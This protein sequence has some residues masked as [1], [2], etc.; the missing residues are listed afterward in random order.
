MSNN[1]VEGED[2]G[3]YVATPDNINRMARG[4]APVGWDGYS[5]QL[6]HWDGIANDFY[7]YSPVSRTLHIIIHQLN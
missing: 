6:H 1:V 4:T 2:Y 5:V 7:N 3:A